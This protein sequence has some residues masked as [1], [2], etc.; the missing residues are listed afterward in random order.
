MTENVARDVNRLCAETAQSPRQG[1]I[2][3]IGQIERLVERSR[4]GGLR[5]VKAGRSTDFALVPGATPWMLL[6]DR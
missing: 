4:P 2:I 5:A 1:R 3:G 6:I